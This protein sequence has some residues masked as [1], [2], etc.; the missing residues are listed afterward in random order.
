MNFLEKIWFKNVAKRIQ[1]LAVILAAVSFVG[2]LALAVYF[3]VAG[4]VSV[5]AT[6]RTAGIQGAVI[7]AVFAVL[8]PALCLPLYGF[9]ALIGHAEKQADTERETKELLRQALVDGALSEDVSR[10]LTQA[11][12]K[13]NFAA[14]Q[15]N[16][17]PAVPVR[18]TATEQQPQAQTHQPQPQAYQP[19]P[20]SS[21]AP[22]ITPL[23]P[24]NDGQTY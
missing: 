22:A 16:A 6:L 8:C 4:L 13:M 7:S 1:L 9:G 19:Q 21:D 17:R 3:L 23:K 11:L 2:L 10:K 12:S 5:D 18:V 20:A 15:T 24:M 14:P